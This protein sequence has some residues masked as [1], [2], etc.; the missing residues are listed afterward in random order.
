[1]HDL[2]LASGGSYPDALAA[3]AAAGARGAGLL[4]VPPDTL[5]T[6]ATAASL[7]ARA[8]QFV[9]LTIAGGPK[10]VSSAVQSTITDGLRIIRTRSA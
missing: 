2:F 4:L 10:A 7:T 1:M 8:D 6:G 5:G 9:R 3:G